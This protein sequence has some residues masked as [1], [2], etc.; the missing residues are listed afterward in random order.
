VL[1]L[2]ANSPIR[3]VKEFCDCYEHDFR[4]AVIKLS[5]IIDMQPIND[6]LKATASMYIQEQQQIDKNN[7]VES[8]IQDIEILNRRNVALCRELREFQE[9]ARL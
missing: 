2:N 7:Y 3:K 6:S 8:L 5:Q 9:G 1:D 4:K